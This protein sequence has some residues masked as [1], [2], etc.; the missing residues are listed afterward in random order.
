M[1]LTV[2]PGEIRVETTG[3]GFAT[4]PDTWVTGTATGGALPVPAAATDLDVAAGDTRLVAD[5]ATGELRLESAAPLPGPRC[6]CRL[7]RTWWS[8]SPS[9]QRER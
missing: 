7:P 8:C 4:G 6:W 9:R 3:D 2:T 5:H 1:L